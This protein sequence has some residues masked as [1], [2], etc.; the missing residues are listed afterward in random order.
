[1]LGTQ[2]TMSFANPPGHGSC[3]KNLIPFGNEP[4]HCVHHE[5]ELDGS[6]WRTR[7]W[8]QFVKVVSYDPCRRDGCRQRV[9]AQWR[10]VAVEG[11]QTLA[12]ALG[13]VGGSGTSCEKH[14]EHRR[15]R[16]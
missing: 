6:Q 1:M 7:E 14:I 5:S 10:D 16:Q 2:V 4:L 15:G 3:L 12:E 11:D 9:A 13:E 8:R